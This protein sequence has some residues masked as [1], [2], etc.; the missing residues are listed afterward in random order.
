MKKFI[1]L[2]TVQFCFLLLIACNNIGSYPEK[3][4]KKKELFEKQ[5]QNLSLIRSRG[6]KTIIFNVYNVKGKNE[7]Y[8]DVL[9]DRNYQ[10]TANSKKYNNDLLKNNSEYEKHLISTVKNK[11]ELM[12]LYDIRDISHE[13]GSQG[14]DMVIYFNSL[15]SLFFIRDRKAVKNKEWIKE[16]EQL[17]KIDENWFYKRD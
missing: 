6:R 10:L 4:L 11:I 13:F 15:E 1:C 14:I 8:L 16:I 3:V 2:V 9:N 7:F 12:D 17:K 5:F